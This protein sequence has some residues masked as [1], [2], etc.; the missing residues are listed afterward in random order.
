MK[1]TKFTALLV[2]ALLATGLG[3]GGATA[4]AATELPSTVC[5]PSE[6]WTEVVPDIQHPAVGEPTIT[7]DNPDYV[8]AIPAVWANFSPNNSQET[9]IGPPAYPTDP[10][11]TWNDH[12]KLPPGQAGPDGVYANGN[13]D[14]GGNWF[15]RQAAKPAVGTPTI[16]VPN[17]DYRPPYTEVVPDIEHP[18]VTCPPVLVDPEKPDVPVVPETPVQ[19]EEPATPEETVT[20]NTPAPAEDQLAE[21]GA[22]DFIVPIGVPLALALIALG[23]VSLL[24]RK[25]S[26]I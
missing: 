5:V 20:D 23:V 24:K 3:V 12:G 19:P 2:G 14:K 18:A 8:P 9:F 4:A 13:P 10:R 16:T 15:Y 25:P 17:P 21:T 6:A 7:V 1:I 26:T 22:E 11:G